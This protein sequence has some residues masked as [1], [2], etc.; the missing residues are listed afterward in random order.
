[1]LRVPRGGTLC[2]TSFALQ[3]GRKKRLAQVQQRDLP[4]RACHR[5]RH[6]AA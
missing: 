2:A 5:S 6:Q 4:E 1:M 3:T